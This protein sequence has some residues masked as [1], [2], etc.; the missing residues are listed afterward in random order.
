MARKIA[1]DTSFVEVLFNLGF[2][3]LR[4]PLPAEEME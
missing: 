2:N 4:Y 1:R 3:L